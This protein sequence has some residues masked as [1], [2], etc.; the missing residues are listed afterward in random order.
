MSLDEYYA[1]NDNACNT[2]K[3]MER[4]KM[5]GIKSALEEKFEEIFE[6]KPWLEDASWVRNAVDYICQGKGKKEDVIAI[7]DTSISNKGKSGLVL[8]TDSVCVKESSNFTTKFIARYEDIDYTYINEDR[9]LG[10]DITALEL[11]MKYGTQYKISLD[12]ISK[13]R[14]MEFLDY[15]SSLYEEEDELVW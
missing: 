13:R 2:L 10:V 12:Q 3:R 11:N 6:Y 7:I 5:S 4:Q 14:L 15:A 9:F 8:T 1:M